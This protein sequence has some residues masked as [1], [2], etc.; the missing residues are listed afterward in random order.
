MI[1]I[2]H[3]RLTE[4]AGSEHVVTQLA[5]EWPD[6][7]VYI[8]IVDR[9]VDAEFS[10]RVVTG[11]LSQAYR[12]L[13]Y[14]S[15]AP[16]L[17][18]AP[19]WLRHC[20]FGSAEAVIISHHA[21]GVAAAEAAGTRPTIA[22]VHSPARWAWNKEM[23]D[24]EAGSLP[25]RLALQALSRLAI[26]TE[27]SAA[28][29]LTTIVANSTAVADRIRKHWNREAEVVHPPV[30]T[31]FY[32]TD[33]TEP[34]EDYFVLAGRL[35]AY[36]RPDIAVKAAAKAGVKLVVVGGGRDL[37]DCRKLAHSKDITFLGRVSNEELRSVLR[38]A[39]ACLMPGEEDFGIVPVE[40]M[41]CGTPMIA[42]GVGGVLDSVI[43]G[44][45]GTLIPPGD[46]ESV[47][48]RF[49]DVLTHFDRAAFDSAQIRRHAE[50]FSRSAFR[51]NMADIVSHALAVPHPS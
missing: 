39:K 41:A 33:P 51:R 1:A 16:L 30:D 28:K 25:G 7:P 10:D 26:S 35:V 31:E 44:V 42:L 50:T 9:R 11:P 24:A 5:R 2:V 48:G 43:D 29:R 38:R 20:D 3:E 23:R 19:T 45:T 13:G 46:D 14:R 4:I 21:F 40:A 12:C 34:V 18:L 15:Y 32:T 8:P 49:A 22:Y 47:I 6:A 37:E 17:P 36:K 27:L